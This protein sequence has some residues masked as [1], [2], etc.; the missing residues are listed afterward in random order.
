[1]DLESRPSEEDILGSSTD[2]PVKPEDDRIRDYDNSFEEVENFGSSDGP[3]DQPGEDQE[4][5]YKDDKADD[6]N[7]L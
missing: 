5:F 3:Q 4:D 7:E 2:R 1:L 6:D